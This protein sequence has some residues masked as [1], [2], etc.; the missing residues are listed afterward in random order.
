MGFMTPE[1]HAG[2][3]MG[4]F[5]LSGRAVSMLGPM[6]FGITN[7]FTGSA[8]IAIV[9]LLIFFVV[10]WALITPVSIQRGKQQAGKA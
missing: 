10:G 4:F 5:N 8:H 6:V 1:K 7:Y 9:S 2:E 3:F